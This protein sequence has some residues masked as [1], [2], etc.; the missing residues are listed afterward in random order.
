MSPQWEG[1]WELD[2][3]DDHENENENEYNDSF[4][5]S[6]SADEGDPKENISEV[7]E[8]SLWASIRDCLAPSDI[9]VLHRGVQLK[10]SPATCVLR[11]VTD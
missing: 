3:G 10:T 9:L 5:A 2:S 1:G 8:S 11:H 7:R 6:D 4:E